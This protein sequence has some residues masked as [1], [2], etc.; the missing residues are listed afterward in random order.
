MLTRH[1]TYAASIAAAIALTTFAAHAADL[2]SE[3]ANA[4]MHAGLAAQAADVAG[5]HSHLHHALNCLVGPK[6]AGYDGQELNPCQNS[7]SGAIPDETDTAKKKALQD[8]ADTATKGITETNLAA[9]QHDAS[10]VATM[11]GAV[12]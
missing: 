2:N 9:A 12:K 4:R 8:A 10:S 6:G 7:G 1:F 3:I 5:V 11:L